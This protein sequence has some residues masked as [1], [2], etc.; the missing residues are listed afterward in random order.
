MVGLS[1]PIK[2]KII[3][4]TSYQDYIKGLNYQKDYIK[5]QSKSEFSYNDVSYLFQIKST[6][7]RY[8]YFT[9]VNIENDEIDSVL[10]TCPQYELTG[11]CKHIAAV[12]VN[13]QNIIFTEKTREEL[14]EISKDVFKSYISKND[15]KKIKQEVFVE[16]E[17]SENKYWRR[18]II[19]SLKIG[20]NKKYVL[21]S[22]LKS[23]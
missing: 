13:Y 8:Y 18:D 15:E 5:L 9:K 6:T 19:I 4:V 16:Y 1:E 7:R 10:C 2:N 14:L 20:I 22:K 23:F 12:L 11:S 21:K 17:I 3:K